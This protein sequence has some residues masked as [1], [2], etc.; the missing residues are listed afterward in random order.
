MEPTP[1]QLWQPQQ[2]QYW[3][4]NLLCH[5]RTPEFSFLFKRFVSRRICVQSW[6]VC[7]LYFSIQWPGVKDPPSL[8]LPPPPAGFVL[9]SRCWIL[10]MSPLAAGAFGQ[11]HVRTGCQEGREK[12]TPELQSSRLC[13]L[14]PP[15]PLGTCWTNFPR[16]MKSSAFL[17][18][19]LIK[20]F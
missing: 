13:C 14:A 5:Q 6:P 11:P 1:Q 12:G 2:W 9:K 8:R 19:H 17:V 7:S 4:L 16:T 18:A 15:C 20:S 3:I 10:T